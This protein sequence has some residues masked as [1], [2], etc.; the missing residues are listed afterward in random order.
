MTDPRRLR[1]EDGFIAELVGSARDD[2]PRAASRAAIAASLGLSLTLANT[3]TAASAS[4]VSAGGATVGGVSAGAGVGAGA[5]VLGKLS[6]SLA[7]KVVVGV[8]LALGTGAV[9]YATRATP[10]GDVLARPAP[11]VVAASPSPRPAEP[12]PLA[13]P[14]P[15]S[16]VVV[17]VPRTPSVRTKRASVPTVVGQVTPTEDAPTQTTPPMNTLAVEVKMLDTALTQLRA[18]APTAAMDELD[19]YAQMFPRGVLRPEATA[20]RIEALVALGK[21]SEARTLAAQFLATHASSPLARRVRAAI[22]G[23]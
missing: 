23:P 4:S 19:R 14:E 3:A 11:S 7:T 6:F 1:D 2:G 5:V 21:L 10:R 12:P 16:P 15:A 17:A 18:G 9:V 22:D 20:A 8:A 13:T